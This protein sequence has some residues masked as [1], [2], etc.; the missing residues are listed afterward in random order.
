MCVF[1]FR[2]LALYLLFSLLR[3]G[4][5]QSANRRTCQITLQLGIGGSESL[6]EWP[7]AFRGVNLRRSHRVLRRQV[8]RSI[9][10]GC[11]FGIFLLACQG[12]LCSAITL[13]VPDEFTGCFATFAPFSACCQWNGRGVGPW[14][15]G[16]VSGRGM[17][18]EKLDDR[19][20]C[21][22]LFLVRFCV[23]ETLERFD[24]IRSLKVT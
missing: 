21:G 1:F 7:K 2:A 20:E 3:Y 16:C 14:T 8:G 22:P 5:R 24:C 19:L 12:F 18:S 13:D 6:I 4:G 15:F 17:T 23:R 11:Q 10:Y 9:F